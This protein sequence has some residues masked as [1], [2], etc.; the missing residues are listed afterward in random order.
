MPAAVWV[1]AAAGLLGSGL[2]YASARGASKAQSRATD[3]AMALER[4]REARAA[5]EKQ[6]QMVAYRQ[7]WERNYEMRR[8]V[9]QRYGVNL[10]PLTPT[11]SPKMDG[12][13]K[14]MPSGAPAQ[15]PAGK[16]GLSLGDISRGPTAQ[17]PMPSSMGGGGYAAP[18]FDSQAPGPMS[19]N[20]QAPMTLGDI[21]WS[22]WRNYGAV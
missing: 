16:T 19:S 13:G 15:A 17:P 1:P 10:P 9:A 3:Q 21:A 18:M 11:S 20:E 12:A 2:Q 6:A 5:R 22:D 8:Q 14:P 7:A 4:E